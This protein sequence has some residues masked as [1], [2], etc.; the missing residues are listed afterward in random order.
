MKDEI[1]SIVREIEECSVFIEYQKSGNN[2]QPS[3]V[4]I[5]THLWH[6][7]T[8]LTSGSVK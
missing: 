1:E 2:F 3:K 7:L 6:K 8:T 5:P 4:E